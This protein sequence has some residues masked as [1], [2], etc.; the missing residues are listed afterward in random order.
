MVSLGSL[1]DSDVEV[2]N[3]LFCSSP[4]RKTTIV[5]DDDSCDD[6]CDE[7]SHVKH[8]SPKQRRKSNFARGAVSG[9]VSTEGSMALREKSTVSIAAVQ[10]G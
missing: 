6:S 3:H 8:G 4:K 10:K 1:S 9:N 5:I 7:G 2:S